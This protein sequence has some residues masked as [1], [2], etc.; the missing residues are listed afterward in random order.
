MFGFRV[1]FVKDAMVEGIPDPLNDQNFKPIHKF[2]ADILSE[3][4]KGYE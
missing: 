4:T 1:N 3:L 2:A